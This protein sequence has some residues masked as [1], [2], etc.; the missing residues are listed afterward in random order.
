MQLQPGTFQRNQE[1][2]LTQHNHQLFDEAYQLHQLQWP[3][4]MLLGQCH[5]QRSQFGLGKRRSLHSTKYGLRY[6]PKQP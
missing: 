1:N 4:Q 6:E 5:S 2:P 3:Q